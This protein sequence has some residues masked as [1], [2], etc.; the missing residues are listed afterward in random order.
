[1]ERYLVAVPRSMPAVPRRYLIVAARRLPAAVVFHSYLI[2]APRSL[3]AAPFLLRR[4]YLVVAP[5]SVRRTFSI[6][7]LRPVLSSLPAATRRYRSRR[8]T[9]GRCS[10][11]QSK[12]CRLH[13]HRG[14]LTLAATYFR[15]G[16][17]VGRS[18]GRTYVIVVSRP[19]PIPFPAATRRRRSRRSTLGR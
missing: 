14:K 1:L 19:V 15:R 10:Q 5:L 9:P 8:W 13:V 4:S 12:Y 11:G 17:V 6:A 2:V 7:V 16:G 18:F 3:P